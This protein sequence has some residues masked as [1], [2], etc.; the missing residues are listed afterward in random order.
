MNGPQNKSL[1]V[2]ISIFVRFHHL[3]MLKL[4]LIKIRLGLI[5]ITFGRWRTPM[6]VTCSVGS[7]GRRRRIAPSCK[8]AKRGTTEREREREREG[9]KGKG[10]REKLGLESLD[11]GGGERAR[12]LECVGSGLPSAVSVSVLSGG[13][14][15]IY[16]STVE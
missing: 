13:G 14:G 11:G 12:K 5:I 4:H 7:K 15:Q 8:L 1:E 10:S 3:I 6:P 16:V 9:R 2:D